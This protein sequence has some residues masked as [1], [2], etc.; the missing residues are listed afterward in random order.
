KGLRDAISAAAA[1]L[2]PLRDVRLQ[3][4]GSGPLVVEEYVLTNPAVNYAAFLLRAVMPTTL[5]VVIAIATGYAVG[6]EFARRS[7]RAWLRCA[8]GSP[9]VALA[10]KLLP[11]FAV[12]F[13]LLA[14]DALILHAGFEL[15]YRGSILMIVVAA[16]LFI[17]AYQSLAALLQLLVHN[18]PTGLSL[19]AIITSPAFGFAGVGLPVLA[20]GAFPQAWGALL[21]LR[22]YQQILFDQAARGSPVHAS[23]VPFAILAGMV[24]GLFTLAWLCLRRSLPP[25]EEDAVLSQD[26]K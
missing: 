5:H 6:T 21:P 18:L 4:V 15:P 26:Q 1:S 2:S 17:A 22:W 20:M 13:T 10:G 23:S 7:R 8:G 19:T 12:F 11:L 14:V 25:R 3:P 9:V 16:A 24:L